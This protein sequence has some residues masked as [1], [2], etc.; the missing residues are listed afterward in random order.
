MEIY[1]NM[2]HSFIIGLFLLLIFSCDSS[3]PVV[4]QCDDGLTEIDGQCFDDCGV[5]NGDGSS[6]FCDSMNCDDNSVCTNDSCDPIQGC[7]HTYNSNSCDDG[8]ACTLGDV[9][10]EGSCASGSP[11]NCDDGNPCS[12]D[13]C[14]SQVGCIYDYSSNN[15]MTCDDGDTC[16]STDTCN[17]GECSGSDIINCP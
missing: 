6:C 1:I 3:N 4:I 14:N 17:E 15:G 5:L 11:I 10:I 12:E 7:I 9:C 16:T 8:D 13:S 2:K